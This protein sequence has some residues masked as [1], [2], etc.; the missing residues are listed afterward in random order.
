M[1][2]RSIKCTNDVVTWLVGW[3]SHCN[4]VQHICIPAAGGVIVPVVET[5]EH[6]TAPGG[7]DHQVGHADGLQAVGATEGLDTP[8]MR[9][10]SIDRSFDSAVE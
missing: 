3:C 4:A 9:I 5:G 1:A 8:G 10:C 7:A 6:V 2:L